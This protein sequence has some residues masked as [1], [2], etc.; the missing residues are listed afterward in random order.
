MLEKIKGMKWGY[1]LF[2]LLSAMLGVLML[3]FNSNMLAGLAIAIGVVVIIAAVVVVLL[4][5]ASRARSA[6]FFF[7]CAVAAAMLTAGIVMLCMRENVMDTI[8]SV[9]GLILTLDGAFKL[10]ENATAREEKNA[11]WWIVSAIA[12]LLITAGYIAVRWSGAEFAI[13]VLGVGFLI[14]AVVNGLSIFLK[15]SRD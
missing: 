3:V 8:I 13:F 12:A 14:D 6:A 15:S 9:L 1:G 4:A 11:V 10:Y 5:L 2:A 7:K